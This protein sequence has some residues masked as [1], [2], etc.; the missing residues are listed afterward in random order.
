MR[1]SIIVCCCVFC[2]ACSIEK[3]YK[4]NHKRKNYSF[5]QVDFKNLVERYL[6]KDQPTDKPI[7]GIYSVSILITKKYKPL[8][9][10]QLKEKVLHQQQNYSTVAIIKENNK[11]AGR[12]YLE[13]P[14]DKDLMPSYSVRG[15]FTAA[16][17]GGILIYKHL[18]RKGKFISYTFSS[19]TSL[20]LLEG[21]KTENRGSTTI[22]HKLSYLRLFPKK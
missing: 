7:E 19:D 3:L 21:V 1:W 16:P 18:E 9:S 6:L 22:V 14:L 5:E 11:N 4:L 15:E 12:E 13:I 2:N 10:A 8:F 17:E 20:D